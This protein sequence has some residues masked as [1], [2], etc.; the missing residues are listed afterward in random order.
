MTLVDGEPSEQID[1]S[2]RAIAYGDGCF[3]TIAKV[4]GVIQLLDDH[5][6]RLQLA[7]Q[8]LDIHFSDW[9]TLKRQ[10]VD[11]SEAERNIVIKVIVSRGSGGRGYSP[12]GADKPIT[13]LSLHQIPVH[14]NDWRES[15]IRLG[16]S[17]VRLAK[18]SALHG[19]KHLNRLEQVLAKQHT[20]NT[21]NDVLVCD[22]DNMIVETSA[23]NIFWQVESQ[24]FTP[25]LSESGVEGVM[26]N[27]FLSV[28]S[29][30]GIRVQVVRAHYT[31]LKYASSIF[32]CNSLMIMV[33]VREICLDGQHNQTIENSNIRGITDLVNKSLNANG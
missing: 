26:R 5:M 18:Q 20:D 24:W 7:C 14:Y 13:I 17:Q 33:P 9:A 32:I 4:S 21:V 31:M 6:Q 27:Y 11:V 22:T 8:I 23:A 3:T 10:I 15:G 28:L 2:D 16:L 29:Q 30:N 25:D 1:A 12:I 19:V